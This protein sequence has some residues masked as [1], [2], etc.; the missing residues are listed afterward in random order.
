M[1]RP[2]KIKSKDNSS[3]H[4]RNLHRDRY[5]FQALIHTSPKLKSYVI[6]N[7]STHD[8]IDFFNPIAVKELNKALLL[9]Y[10]GLTYWDIPDGYLCPSIPGRADYIHYMADILALFHQGKVPK[11]KK[12]QALDIGI[13]ANAVY[14]IIGIH[15]YGW[16]FIG[17]EVHAPSIASAQNII[18]QN[19]SLQGKLILRKQPNINKIFEH[20]I[21][22][23]EFIDIVICNPPFH[24]S[25]KEA[26]LANT[27]KLKNLTQDIE[28]L[29]SL[30][31]GG[32][33]NELWRNGGELKICTRYDP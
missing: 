3:L 21:Q 30:N 1:S 33:D 15:E 13:G 26:H 17:S 9:H 32:Q 12:I 16:Q 10:Y 23:D 24:D 27:R 18:D 11:G 22:K 8:T 29:P 4:T 25:S 7:K 28:P 19:P 31:F 5:D 6:R 2:V 20:I 14:S